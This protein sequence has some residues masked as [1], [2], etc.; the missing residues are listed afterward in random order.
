MKRNNIFMYIFLIIVIFSFAFYNSQ[1][2]T[3]HFTPFIRKY[4]RPHMRNLR[5]YKENLVDKIY[6]QTNSFLKRNHLY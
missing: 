2:N 3:E 4:Y 6:R 5:I 1:F